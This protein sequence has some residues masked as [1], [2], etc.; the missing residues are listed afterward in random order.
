VGEIMGGNIANH[1]PLKIK[2]TQIKIFDVMGKSTK[3]S[4]VSKRN[5]VK[6]ELYSYITVN[7][8]NKCLT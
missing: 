2:L 6:K 7:Q 4:L 8:Y 5:E 3:I 1:L